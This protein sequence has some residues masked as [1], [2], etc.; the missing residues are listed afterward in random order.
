VDTKGKRTPK[1]SK[2]GK[3]ELPTLS[4]SASQTINKGPKKPAQKG[5]KVGKQSI[6]EKVPKRGHNKR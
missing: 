5:T 1:G 2:A 4:S 3:E 6:L